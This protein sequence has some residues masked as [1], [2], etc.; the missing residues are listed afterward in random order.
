MDWL[1]NT[2]GGIF[3]ATDSLEFKGDTLQLCLLALHQ[4]IEV[5]MVYCI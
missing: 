1:K 5:V 3:G 4:D 2:S